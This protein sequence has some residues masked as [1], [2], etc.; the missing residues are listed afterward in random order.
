MG[1]NNPEM[2]QPDRFP[3]PDGRF[4]VLRG[5]HEVKMSHWILAAGLWETRGNRLLTSLGTSEWSTDDVVWA[6]DSSFVTVTLRRY[7]G[8]APSVVVD[9]HP[10]TRKAVPRVRE[11]VPPL[12]FEGLSLFLES[13][14]RRNRYRQFP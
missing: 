9:L 7:P 3:S 8:D 13:F 2:I 14:Y 5:V 6:P 1:Q 4:H 10:E 11:E 12:P